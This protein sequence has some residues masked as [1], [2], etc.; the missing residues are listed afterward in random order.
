[1]RIDLNIH[2]L[3]WTNEKIFVCCFLQ[4]LILRNKITSKK[5]RYRMVKPREFRTSFFYRWRCYFHFGSMLFSTQILELFNMK[6]S[7]TIDQ[8]RICKK[9]YDDPLV[10][11][12]M[13]LFFLLVSMD[14][15]PTNFTCPTDVSTCPGQ[16]IL[17]RPGS[18]LIRM[19]Y[20]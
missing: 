9:N 8:T 12:C 3:R 7:K 19:H 10:Y 2:I 13:G 4:F 5:T 14:K 11:F 17:S 6:L 20:S 16:T 15:W 18:I 1:M